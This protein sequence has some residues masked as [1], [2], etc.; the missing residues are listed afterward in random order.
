MYN[1]YTRRYLCT[2]YTLEGIY[3]QYIQL[4]I[5]RDSDVYRRTE[6]IVNINI[7]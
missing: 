4:T 7:N 2:I 1:I 6:I 3:V 5:I